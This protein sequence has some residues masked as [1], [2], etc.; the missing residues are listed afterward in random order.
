MDNNLGY[1]FAAFAVAIVDFR[2]SKSASDKLA[3]L[4]NTRP[5]RTPG[6]VACCSIG[7]NGCK[8]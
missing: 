4:I 8:T 7:C 6:S 3:S 1:L 5:A 2:N